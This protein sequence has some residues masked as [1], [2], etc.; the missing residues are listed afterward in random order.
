MSEARVRLPGETKPKYPDNP[1]DVE[2]VTVACKVPNGLILHLQQKIKRW[3]Q[4]PG[5]AREVD[6]WIRL[7][8]E[9]VYIK[10]SSVDIDGLKRGNFDQALVGGAYGYALTF[11]V[12]KKFWDTWLEQ[13]KD[14]LLV[15][16]KQIF[17]YKSEADTR[18]EA[19]ECRD[20]KSGLEPIDQDNPASKSR[21]LRGIRRGTKRDD[22]V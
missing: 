19:S 3:E 5:G 6:A 8:D 2:T 11:N 21:E 1:P 20:V 9:E 10:G 15:K 7:A 16:N 18:A 17:A 4:G 14:T 13:N 12:S 22:D